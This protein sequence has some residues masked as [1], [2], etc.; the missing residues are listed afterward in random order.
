MLYCLELLAKALLVKA[1]RFVM[2]DLNVVLLIR[3]IRAQLKVSQVD[4]TAIHLTILPPGI[5]DG[6]A[7]QLYFQR[8]LHDGFYMNHCICVF[9][10][11]SESIE[12]QQNFPELPAGSALSPRTD[13]PSLR[14]YL[15]G[16][17]KR[18]KRPH[19]DRAAQG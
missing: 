18:T 7:W 10:A 2:T 15:Q 16:S 5:G 13:T 9:V 14:G 1:L 4:L 6:R 11:K 17:G 12:F 19:T 8:W 3:F